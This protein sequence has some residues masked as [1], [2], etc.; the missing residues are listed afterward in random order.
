MPMTAF[1]YPHRSSC[2]IH[3]LLY[4]SRDVA[5]TAATTAKQVR[6]TLPNVTR[7]IDVLP[8]G[9]VTEAVVPLPFW[10]VFTVRIGQPQAFPLLSTPVIPVTPVVP[11]V[12]LQ[13]LVVTTVVVVLVPLLLVL[14]WETEMLAIAVLL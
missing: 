5:K 1:Q 9:E 6:S 2:F 11:F 12:Q 8:I 3:C 7:V 14:L 10:V 4:T 13:V